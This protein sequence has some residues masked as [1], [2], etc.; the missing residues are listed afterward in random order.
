MLLLYALLGLLGFA[1]TARLMTWR[2]RHALT[3]GTGTALAALAIVT[4]FSIGV[5]LAPVALLVLA[6][7]AVPHLRPLDRAA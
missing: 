2:S 4:G 3:A 1:L 6:L 5:Y 7:A